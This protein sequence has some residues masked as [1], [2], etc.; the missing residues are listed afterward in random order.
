MNM[1]KV[2]GK[3]IA[4]LCIVATS[5]AFAA[6]GVDHGF[7]KTSFPGGEF[8]LDVTDLKVKGQGGFI[9]STRSW[10]GDHWE[11][12]RRWGSLYLP[13]M[14]P[15][16]RIGSISV[17]SQS[18]GGASMSSIGTEMT[19][20]VRN[21]SVFKL[22]VS[23]RLFGDNSPVSENHYYREVAVSD[24][25]NPEFVRMMDNFIVKRSGGTGYYWSDRNGNKVFYNPD[26]I[27][28]G[29]QDKN[30]NKVTLHR[31]SA[32]DVKTVK[33][34]NGNI[35]LEYTYETIEIT[36]DEP[37]ES[38]E[39]VISANRVKS[40]TDYSGRA[41][42][43]DYND[44]GQ[45]EKV[46][47]PLGKEWVYGYSS[48]GLLNSVT[49]PEGRVTDLV[50]SS[51]GHIALLGFE[52]GRQFS[53][54][55]SGGDEAREIRTDAAGTVTE[56]WYNR[57]RQPIK[58]VVNG[59]EEF[60]AVYHTAESQLDNIRRIS[61]SGGGGGG[62][63]G[64]C[65]GGGGGGG[66]VIRLPTVTHITNAVIKDRYGEEI[67]IDY[68]VL[69]QVTKKKRLSDGATQTF[70]YHGHWDLPV[71][72]VDWNG[73]VTEYSYDGNGNLKRLTEAKGTAVERVTEYSWD[74]HGNLKTE[75]FLAD[76]NTQEAL[77]TYHYDDY[78]NVTSVENPG[79]TVGYVNAA[80]PEHD[81][82]GNPPVMVDERGKVWKYTYDDVGNR[83]SATDPLPRT[84]DFHYN[85]AGDIT[86]ITLPNTKT[87]S[88]TVDHSGKPLVVTNAL[89]QNT[90]FTYK[91]GRI[92]SITL[93]G[94]EAQD[95]GYNDRGQLAKHEDASGNVTHYR[96]DGARLAEIGY[97]TYKETF[98]QDV[99]GR[100]KASQ[101]RSAADGINQQRNYSYDALGNPTLA[102]DAE[103]EP[104]E[105][106]Y[107]AL[108]RLSKVIDARN[109]VT[110][111][112]YDDRDNLISVTDPE[113]KTTLFTYD[114]SDRLVNEERPEGETRSYTYYSDGL[115]ETETNGK[116]AITLFSYDDA[117]QLKKVEYFADAAAR[118]N[119]TAGKA[120]D[121][122]Y[123][124][125]GLLKHYDDQQSVG[126]Y[127]YDDLGRLKTVTVN[128]GP[129]TKSHSYTYD[130][131]G[132]RKTYTNP[133]G[134]TYTY[135]Y[136]A[137]GDF[138]S[139]AI[140]NEGAI[141]V[142]DYKWRAPQEWLFPGGTRI[143][144]ATD[145]LLRP[146]DT[147]LLDPAGNGK[148]SRV[149]TYDQENHITGIATE[150]GHH[151][152]TLDE[153]YRLTVAAY[154]IESQLQDEA[155]TYDG[156]GNR[157][158]ENGSDT[159]SYNANHQLESRPAVTYGYDENGH[160]VSKT[161]GVSVTTYEYDL[162][163][164]MKAVKKDGVTLGSYTYDPF[165]R[166]V[167][168]ATGSGTVYFHYDDTGLLAEYDASG[169]LLNEY[170]YTPG[171]TWMTNPLF[172]RDSTGKVHYYYNSHLG[173]PLKL[174]DKAGKVTWAARS[175]AFGETEVVVAE[176][177]NVLRFP[178]QYWDGETGLHYNFYRYYLPE[179]G[180]YIQ[181]DPIGVSGGLNFYV[182]VNSSPVHFVDPTGEVAVIGGAAS[183]AAG[184]ALAAAMGCDYG[185]KDAL[186]DFA[187]GFV[188]VGVL[189]KAAKMAKVRK[190]RKLAESEN[191]VRKN[192]GNKVVEH[193][194]GANGE[195]I[196]IKHKGSLNAPGKRSQG[197][198]VEYKTGQGEWKDPFTGEIGGKRDYGI[199][200]V[201]LE[202]NN[203]GG[204]AAV[205]AMIGAEACGC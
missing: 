48:N 104:T 32:G 170:Q 115:R 162:A 117:G 45:L 43:Y 193:Y 97:P 89:E 158:T 12:N 83:L 116:G 165:G 65:G 23:G 58:K 120:V 143:R 160:T 95:F 139:L 202:S 111:L 126:D 19:T 199:T 151:T 46:T 103:S 80:F 110:E 1:L 10:V 59:E 181:S 108:G 28:T 187:L 205:G 41:T 61:S 109:G 49:D 188:G 87:T 177:E 125:L 71:R 52:D 164:R 96:Y 21:G 190:V 60:T 88:W 150:N 183:V 182:Y 185:A 33:D 194:K 11:F 196:K 7:D 171:S 24:K 113:L 73:V 179:A 77:Y 141:T 204:A 26:G 78:G 90:T 148:A 64:S 130:N 142:T 100:A 101:T 86:G 50:S 9:R 144:T 72:E 156:V 44:L 4:P 137:T 47:D 201:S 118:N 99:L 197:A 62:G 145:G 105:N 169:Q 94:G 69:G 91:A 51:E 93:P 55:Y 63:G 146:Q 189:N 153:L 134:V 106:I 17:S 147:A 122:D 155:Y 68:N 8:R 161:E 186:I 102:T 14:E 29:Y 92:D 200:H 163:E 34:T 3:W 74:A 178:G 66:T 25:S 37:T 15:T 79:G 70:K 5:G 84:T 75:R 180:R 42:L 35:A 157:L 140:P 175:Q 119:N 38:G 131:N 138:K 152:Y 166:R 174:F 135:H 132:R 176:T 136:T 98:T 2:M 76:S 53:F 56:T 149:Y 39:S 127:T 30:G 31:N 112:G 81:V 128:Y 129:F 82:L 114:A 67:H 168:K 173:Q 40:V 22:P 191:M 154:A 6:P 20:I 121:F 184:M 172:K 16:V 195:Y 54:S 159:W 57:F 27:A 167:S 13:G 198:R 107:D 123:N 36:L 192:P 133:E 85:G 124:A 18:C 203:P